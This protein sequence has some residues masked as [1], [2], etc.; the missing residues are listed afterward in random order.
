MHL[1]NSTLS[2]LVLFA[3][4]LIVLLVVLLAPAAIRDR[5]ARA[6]MGRPSAR[7]VEELLDGQARSIQRL[8]GAARQLALG[9]R[10][11]GELAEDAIR[12]VG[13]VRFDAFEDMGGQLSF[14]AAL[15]DGHGDGVVITSING[16]HDTR[17]YA[18]RVVKG[19]SVHNLADEEREA[20]R[21]ALAGADRMGPE[22]AR[23]QGG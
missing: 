7:R 15:L 20:I 18:K 17:V 9:E 5:R 3:L 13:L 6:R 12:H 16:R 19:A 4:A 21:Q 22:K 23:A 11:L 8:E 1:S 10:Q 14:S 2:L